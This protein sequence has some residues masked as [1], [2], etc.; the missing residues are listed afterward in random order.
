MNWSLQCNQTYRKQQDGKGTLKK[1]RCKSWTGNEWKIRESFPGFWNNLSC[2]NVWGL[3]IYDGYLEADWLIVT[4]EWSQLE[5]SATKEKWRS[6]VIDV[7][8]SRYL[9]LSF[10]LSTRSCVQPLSQWDTHD[11]MYSDVRQSSCCLSGVFC[12]QNELLPESF[13]L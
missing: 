12:F 11:H 1:I 5:D 9:F 6:S 3:L 8:Q 2:R 7:F 10:F 4:P 13:L